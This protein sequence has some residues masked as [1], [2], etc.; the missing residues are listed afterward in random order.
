MDSTR[1]R[2]FPSFISNWKYYDNGN[3]SNSYP[4]VGSNSYLTGDQTTFSYRTGKG[5]EFGDRPSTGE[6]VETS[7]S[8][9][10][11]MKELRDEYR[12]DLG[13][14]KHDM[15]HEFWTTRN[16][17]LWP[18]LAT[19]HN[20]AGPWGNI[21]LTGA[22]PTIVSSPTFP[23]M[24]YPSSAS[25]N[26]DG[27]KLIG[28]TIPTA[29]EV[30]LAAF[31]GELREGLPRVVGLQA[32]MKRGSP[33]S[34]GSEHLNMQFGVKPL[35]ADLQKLARGVLSMQTRVDQY[36]RDSGRNVRRRAEL[37]G[38]STSIQRPDITWPTQLPFFGVTD[39]VPS[40]Y[41]Y[42]P[43]ITTCV[44]SYTSETWFAG[45]YTYHLSEAHS[46][47]GK[48]KRYEELAN[49]ALGTRFDAD[50]AYQLTPWSWLV[51]WFSDTGSF[52]HNVQ[53]LSSDS[54]VL[55]YG[56]VM[57]HTKCVRIYSKVGHVPRFPGSAPTSFHLYL[58]SEKKQRTRATPYGFGVDLSTL[59]PA[60][61]GILAA[62]GL[63]KSGS[64]LR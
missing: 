9:L 54:L 48:L 38:S 21:K 16:E 28:K 18:P 15:G 51:D 50:V 44:D 24:S 7:G 64:T 17:I 12:G 46:F 25:I 32:L 62:L 27:A 42:D 56:Y 6:F 52:I 11:F 55:R 49:Q 47:L 35:I 26:A 63:T 39:M 19:Y 1:S 29:P 31:L 34:L 14:T 37:Q 2:T 61:L 4:H 40:F 3:T 58:T 53:A 23:P 57:H 41:S 33:G 59:N 13:R 43:P 30:G 36:Q 60:R 45:S 22:I 5:A 20:P 8:R 10:D